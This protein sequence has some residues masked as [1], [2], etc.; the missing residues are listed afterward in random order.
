[1]RLELSIQSLLTIGCIVLLVML[2]LSDLLS[3]VG[4]K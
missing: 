4:A 1:M 3:I 2:G